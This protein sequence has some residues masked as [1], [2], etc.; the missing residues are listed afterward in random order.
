MPIRANQCVH[1]A[2]EAQFLLFHL[3][4]Q[5]MQFCSPNYNFVSVCV[6]CKTVFISVVCPR[7]YPPLFFGF[8]VKSC[9]RMQVVLNVSRVS[10]GVNT[11]IRYEPLLNVNRQ[12]INGIC[13]QQITNMSKQCLYIVWPFSRRVSVILF[14]IS[15]VWCSEWSL[16]L[17]SSSASE[18]RLY[19]HWE[20]KTCGKCSPCRFSERR[21]S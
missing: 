10:P 16:T 13:R 11:D 6:H 15:T 4:M 1:G 17:T 3:Q 8:V 18:L 7:Y 14:L 5:V 2:K 21:K 19:I 12:S 20:K 9:L